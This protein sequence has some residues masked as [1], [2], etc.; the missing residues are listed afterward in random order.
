MSRF[1][2]YVKK[3]H[4][5]FLAIG[6][7]AAF[8]ITVTYATPPSSP[9]TAGS[10][11]DPQCAP[12]SSNCTV[13]ISGGGGGSS[14]WDTVTGGI[15]YAG[16]KV[17]I[18]TTTP[19]TALDLEGDG[20][21][22]AAG[23]YGSGVAVPD[24]STGTRMQW[25]PSASAFRA[26]TIT[27]DG[28]G[29]WDSANVGQYS[30]AFGADNIASGQLSTAFGAGNN[31]SGMA[32]VVFGQA[33]TASGDNSA[34]FGFLTA[35]SNQY[36]TSF[37]IQ[38]IASGIAAA[39]FG[40]QSI[41][42]GTFSA[43]F[44]NYTK[45]D[46]YNDFAIG[47][48]NVGGGDP[49]NWV[50][51]DPLFE[52]GNGTGLGSLSNALTV[53][54]NGNLGINTATPIAALNVAGDGAI[55]ASGTNGSGIPVPDLGAGTRMEWIPSKSAFRA[56]TAFGTEWD[57]ANVGQYSVAFGQGS[58]ASSN[59]TT[60][61]GYN[62]VASTEFAT[63]FGN[64]TTASGQLS[65]A[66]GNSTTASGAVSTTF[67][68]LTIASNSYATAFGDTTTA[69][70]FASTS[71]GV[72]TIASARQS[73]AFGNGT[74]ASGVTSAAFG[75]GTTANSYN[76]FVVGRNNTGLANSSGSWVGTDPL[77]EVGNGASSS[78]LSNALTVLKNGKAIFGGQIFQDAQSGGQG[79][80]IQNTSIGGAVIIN[81]PT[82]VGATQQIIID[83]PSTQI[84]FHTGNNDGSSYGG[85]IARP[86]AGVTNIF[87]NSSQGTGGVELSTAGT[88]RLFAGI[89]GYIGIAN[90]A[91]GYLFTVGSSSVPTGI[92]AH[93]ETAA[94]TCDL[95]PTNVGG[96]SCTSDMNA[97]KNITNLADNSTW[98]FVNNIGVANQT[99]FDKITALKPVQYNFNVENDNTQKHIGFIAQDV[100]QIFPDLV[101][102]NPDGKKTLNYTGL[103]P[104]TVEAI[105]EMNFNIINIADLTKTNTWRDSL[106]AWFGNSTNGIQNIF[107]KQITTPTLCVG[108]NDNKTCITK[109]QL[110]H[111]LQQ[112]STSESTAA[113]TDSTNSP[114]A[115][116]VVSQNPDTSTQS[117]AVSDI[118]TSLPVVTPPVDSQTPSIDPIV[119]AN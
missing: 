33:N 90:I 32:S 118:T 30:T 37:G 101:A 58:T 27:G 66:F 55:I 51:T 85:G 109:D 69:S 15:N 48:F 111:L 117:P 116:T 113:Q 106:I 95:D 92:I 39:S 4:T 9:Y 83:Q 82:N 71:F 17:G 6:F 59:F 2:T 24:F 68:A 57:D 8:S 56:G 7:L 12:G 96:L 80:V 53:L 14:Q 75:D 112:Q 52:I 50:D 100:E 104:Y 97:K 114:Q 11:L 91:P 70:G 5:F 99:I 110:D 81:T 25:I 73:V 41:A 93:F 98:N 115:T 103:I 67:G 88:V 38:T 26:G 78:S 74:T 19:Q 21:I 94:G 36:A 31:A 63:A 29:D 40:Q 34:A 87:S 61:F 79:L 43:A 119:P 77:F 84:I 45:A 42:S 62:T 46:S 49:T 54:K 76:D 16:G 65:T 105:K 47:R 22:I 1:F 108:T 3:H 44:G 72:N 64:S 35:A 28:V 23:T 86:A 18:G 60:A 20:A 10:T 107:S 102:T 89:N 13:A